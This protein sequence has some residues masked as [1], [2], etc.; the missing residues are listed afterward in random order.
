MSESWKHAESLVRAARA[1]GAEGAEALVVGSRI[2]HCV[3]ATG[4][5]ALREEKRAWIRVYGADGSVGIAQGGLDAGALLAA[6]QAAAE[7]G[8]AGGGPAPRLDVPTRGLGILDP[9]QSSLDDEQ[10]QSVVE[11]AIDDCG[12]VDRRVLP[13]EF[14]YDEVVQDRGFASSLGV[15]LGEQS[16]RYRLTGAARLRGVD[17]QVTGAI[18]S[19]NF[20]EVGSKPLGVA[21]GRRA[22]ALGRSAP[23][24]AS[25]VPLALAPAVIAELLPRIVRAFRAELVSSGA[26][27]LA[28]REQR[29]FGSSVLHLV[30]DAALLGGYA[31]RSC[32]D[33]GVPPVPVNLIK[34]GRLGGL[35]QGVEA[36]RTTDA[37]PSGHETWD[38][39][40]WLGNLV[41]RAG[42]RSRNMIFPELGTLVLVDDLVSVERCDLR[43]GELELLVHAHRYESTQAQGFCGVQRIVCHVDDLFGGVTH[44]LNDQARV[45]V[46]DTPTWIVTGVWFS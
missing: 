5:V 11:D 33:R 31:T 38:G 27:F 3:E 40:A 7:P 25:A 46:V 41:V 37:R 20:A 15:S 22:V 1:A 18:T 43:T 44:I 6:A 28:G 4:P 9:R 39:G 16:T 19:R 2:H 17:V 23:L 30:D 29:P 21:L 12:G 32:D 36:A 8:P 24:P 26:S 45:G 42:N 13:G 34:E 35:Y 14:A 10:R